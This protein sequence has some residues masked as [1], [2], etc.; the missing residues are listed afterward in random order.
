MRIMPGREAQPERK[1][2]LLGVRSAY[3]D[4]LEAKLA[5]TERDLETA[6]TE[7]ESLSTAFRSAHSALEETAGWSKRLPEALRDLANLAA[8]NVSE[9][10]PEQTLANAILT[11][12]G[13]HLLASV[14]VTRGDPTGE[15]ERRTER[16]E[17][18]RPISTVTRL[19]ACEANCTW[20]PGVEAGPDTTDVIEGLAAAVVCS[21]AGAANARAEREVMT[22]LG[23]RRSLARHLALRDR[24]NQ[25]AQLIRVRVDGESAIAH[26]ELY[27]RL[28]WS[29][30]LAELASVLD[31][32]A[33]AHGGQAYQAGDREFRVLVDADKAQQA[34]EL[35]ERATE[36]YDDLRIRI[37]VP[38]G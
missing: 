26:R 15:L 32:V 11:V 22:Q 6:R 25:P 27:G 30:A 17:H 10:A 2:A 19:G 16:N 1:R 18:G 8:G 36:E 34:R 12:A 3:V 4:E 7:N 20:Q 24:Q 9:E 35:T 21:L 29:A 33:R 38:Q 37:D 14:S 5:T 28:A 31:R 13:E 23:D